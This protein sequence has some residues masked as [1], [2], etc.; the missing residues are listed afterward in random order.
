MAVLNNF[1]GVRYP[2]PDHQRLKTFLSSSCAIH[3]IH[4][5]ALN[6]TMLTVNSRSQSSV[7]TLR[8]IWTTPGG[9][10]PTSASL[11]LKKKYCSI[12]STCQS[13]CINVN[14]KQPL[15][16]RG[17]FV[18]CNPQKKPVKFEM[19]LHFMGNVKLVA[20]LTYYLCIYLFSGQTNKNMKIKNVSAIMKSRKNRL[21]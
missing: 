14:F 13:S 12:N 11:K 15:Q 6:G 10:S 19:F 21:E 3:F 7:K 17:P 20:Q 4:R 2:A 9:R 16:R 1:Y 5:M 18:K 8:A